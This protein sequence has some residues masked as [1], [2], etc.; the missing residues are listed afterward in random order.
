VIG[1]EHGNSVQGRPGEDRLIAAY[2]AIDR[3]ANG[4]GL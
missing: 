4:E 2:R 3:T 1:M